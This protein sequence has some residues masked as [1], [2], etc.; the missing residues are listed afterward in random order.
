M[1]SRPYVGLPGSHQSSLPHLTID[2]KVKRSSDG[3][4]PAAALE[5]NKC[6]T[7]DNR[8]WLTQKLRKVT[9]PQRRGSRTLHQ[10]IFKIRDGRQA[11]ARYQEGKDHHV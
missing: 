10:L 5:L 3:P 1:F 7:Y 8:R 11:A 2:Q 9:V 6:K 4:G